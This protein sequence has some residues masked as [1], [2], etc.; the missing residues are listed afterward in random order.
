M[1]DLILV[2]ILNFNFVPINI[3]QEVWNQDNNLNNAIHYFTNHIH[4]TFNTNKYFFR[5]DC[6][7]GFW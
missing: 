5:R 2:M 1:K 4:K 6:L 7:Y 3:E